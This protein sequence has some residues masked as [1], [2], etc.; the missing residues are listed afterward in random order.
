[1]NEYVLK[2]NHLSKKYKST[3]AL[4]KVNISIK[5][6]AIYGF[7]GQN[8]AGKSTLI[9]LVCGL[10][11]PTTGSLELFG[12]TS[13]RAL[14]QNRKRI[15]TI[16]EGPALYPNMT[17]AE[18]LE[19]HRLLKGIP[20]KECIEKTLALVGLQD[21]RKKKARNFSLGMKQRLGIAI[22]LLGDPEFLILDEPINGLDPMG[23][24]EIRGLLKKLNEEHGI[25][26]F[27]SSHILSELHLLATHYGIIHKGNLIDQLS[28]KEL[29]DK[30]Q[31]YLHIKV[32]H[33]D[34]AI[35]VL[36][37]HFK[38][39]SFE[40]MPNGSIKMFDHI[41]DPGEVSQTLVHQG[42]VIEE[43]MPMGED[44]ETYFSHQIGGVHHG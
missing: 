17:A 42:L 19:A 4:D 13:E 36:E 8:G 28:L 21:T 9:R 11:E 30:C 44:L 37:N 29:N 10:A 14:I 39:K 1:M 3:M 2:T 15:G 7:I 32:N 12:N 27:I 22:A 5:K 23:V 41:N 6:G 43:F 25:T 38:M 20:G 34:K 35:T 40:V 33:P 26:I 18:N 16:I 24:V 31:Q